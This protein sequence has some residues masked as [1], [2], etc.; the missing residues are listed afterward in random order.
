MWVL[1]Q[2]FKSVHSTKPQASRMESAEIFVVCK[3]FLAPS[4]IDQKLL[5]PKHVFQEV[6]VKK[7]EEKINL[8]KL[9]VSNKGGVALPNM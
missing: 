6:E 8:C 2:L 4:V 7:T 3:G 1:R 9:Q 5:D